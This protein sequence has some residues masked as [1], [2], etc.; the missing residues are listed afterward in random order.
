MAINIQ[1]TLLIILISGKP[2]EDVG[3]PAIN[4]GTPENWILIAK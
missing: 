3:I 1:E 2:D 4:L